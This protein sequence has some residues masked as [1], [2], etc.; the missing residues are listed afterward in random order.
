MPGISAEEETRCRL[1]EAVANKAGL[2]SAV[3]GLTTTIDEYEKHL[4]SKREAKAEVDQAQADYDDQA[5]IARTIYARQVVKD[6]TKTFIPDGN[7]RRQVTAPEAASWV[8]WAVAT[9]S[10]VAATAKPLAAAKQR[11][12]ETDDQIKVCERRVSASKYAAEAAVALCNILAT[13]FHPI[14]ASRG[15]ASTTTPPNNKEQTR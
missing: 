5:G 13:A 15:P 3:A 8:E 4:G 9:D 6:G 14:S 7:E 12:E 11:L 10:E 2:Q 1:L